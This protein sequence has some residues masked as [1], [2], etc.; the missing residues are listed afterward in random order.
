MRSESRLNVGCQPGV[1]PVLMDRAQKDIDV[2][3][4]AHVAGGASRAPGWFALAFLAKIVPTR[5]RVRRTCHAV[6][7]REHRFC[8]LQYLGG[9]S[10]PRREI[11]VETAKPAEALGDAW[12]PPTRCGNSGRF[13]GQPPRE[14]AKPAE[15]HG[16]RWGPPTRCW[17]SERFGGQP[18]REMRAEAGEPGGNRTPNP[19]I[20]SRVRRIR[21]PKKLSD[22]DD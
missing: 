15:A 19:Q 14:R 1:I 8:D 16:E 22:S 13:G 9:G 10:Q 21:S 11:R 7:E 3:L 6:G 2:P 17:N 12:V 4:F 5:S 18:P 20:K